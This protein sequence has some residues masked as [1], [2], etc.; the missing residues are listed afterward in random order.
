MNNYYLYKHNFH[1]AL[2]TNDSFIK[3]AWMTSQS[4]VPGLLD[5]NSQIYEAMED[6]K[7][8]FNSIK[9]SN[10]KKQLSEL[11]VKYE[12]DQLNHENYRLETKNRRILVITLF[13][14]L[15]LVMSICF[16]LYYDLKKD[17][18]KKF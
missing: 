5:I 2:I 13:M 12:V 14:V 10:L 9:S 17:R 18:W 1:N 3:Y 4:N 6:N 16:Y 15:V 7:N 11:Q 8:A